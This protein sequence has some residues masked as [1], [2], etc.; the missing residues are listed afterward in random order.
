VYPPAVR[1][2]LHG[3]LGLGLILLVTVSLFLDAESVTGWTTPIAWWGLILLLDAVVGRARGASP[4]LA[5]PGRLLGW[6]ATSLVFWLAFEG[7]NLHLRNWHYVGLPGPLWRRLFGYTIS[8]STVVPGVFLAAEALSAG[9][10]F[11]RARGPRLRTGRGWEAGTIALG[12]LLVVVPL[13]VRERIAEWLYAP[14]W[15]GF[16]FLLDPLNRW[17]GAPSLLADWERGA[18]GRTHRLLLAGLLCGILWEGWNSLAATKW[19]YT[20]PVVPQIRYFEMPLVGFLGFAP[21]A[22]ELF[23]MFHLCAAAWDALWGR[24]PDPERAPRFAAPAPAA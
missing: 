16:F 15:L 4:L 6:C 13:L 14:I 9:G 8:F 23:A 19:V 22:L 24:R 21:F 3:W 17:L 12:A 10:L 20:V 7:T 2:P 1:T 11:A 5:H 18:W